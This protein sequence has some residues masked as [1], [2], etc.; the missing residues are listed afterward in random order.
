MLREKLSAL[1]RSCFA[2]KAGDLP[3]WQIPLD[4]YVSPCFLRPAKWQSDPPADRRAAYRQPLLVI[5][6]L[7]VATGSTS[8][9]V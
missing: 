9:S 2:R 8:T 1:S 3:S 7:P 6:V 4:V 5:R